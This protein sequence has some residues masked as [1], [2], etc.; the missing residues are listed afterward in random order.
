MSL[1]DPDSIQGTAY[2]VVGYTP[3]EDN[4]FT[5]DEKEFYFLSIEESSHPH[6]LK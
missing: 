2:L 1:P 4:R 3:G 5:G 6:F